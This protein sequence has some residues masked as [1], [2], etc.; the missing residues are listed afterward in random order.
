MKLFLQLKPI[1]N[2]I[3]HFQIS[4]D[5]VELGDF[6]SGVAEEVCY[7]SRRQGLDVAVFIL[8]T[9]DQSGGESVAERV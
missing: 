6:R 7:L 1:R 4:L 9:V 2:P 8:R 5:V 3:E